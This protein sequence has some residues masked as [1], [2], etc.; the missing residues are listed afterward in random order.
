M[1]VL[2]DASEWA[3]ETFGHCEL[4][5][6]RR[7]ARAVKVAAGLARQVGSSFLKSC[8]GDSAAVEGIYRLLRNAAV[9]PQALAEGGFE[10]TVRRAQSCA[11]VLAIEDT[12]FLSYRHKSADDLGE[13][14][15]KTSAKSKG[16]VVHS[17]LLV[18]GQSGQTVG[19]VE[20][21]RWKRDAQTHGKK[22]QR[23][24]RPYEEKESF[25]WQR[26]GVA[27]R[28]R[29]GEALS[30]RVISVCDRE[31]DIAEYLAWQESVE[32]RYVV[33]SSADRRLEAST[34][35]LWTEVEKQPVLGK[36]VIAV[37]QRG[38]RP[39]REATVVLRACKVTLKLP[40]GVKNVTCNAVLVREMQPP[41]GAEAL[42]WLLLTTESIDSL[43]DTLDVLWMYG[44]RWRIEEFH[45]AWKSGTGVEALRARCADNLERG[46]VM[47]MFVAIRLL[48]LQELASAPMPRPSMPTA[49]LPEVP[50]DDV[51]SELEWKVLYATT[52]KK[53][54]PSKPP[55]AQWAYRTIA[56]LGGWANTQ[57][58]GRPGWESIWRGMFRL[59]ERV[60]GYLLA[61]NTCK[62][63]DQ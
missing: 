12:T 54:P 3:E 35:G 47:L 36:H 5:D 25:K 59:A 40:R 2:T 22:H 10:G 27:M 19:L 30:Q 4:G 61:T 26:A 7:T 45:K 39:A 21:S 63:C 9:D 14:C 37:P 53:S 49:S 24:R 42:E 43:T 50:C 16:F 8:E 17:T 51:L 44:R 58:S 48:Q 46:A 13:I 62:K 32:G 20:Q 55:S 41:K 11:V 29:L 28:S 23:K 34:Q 56:K 52:T 1:Y 31:A 15:T 6:T 38:G 60:E 57:R 33:R 18:D